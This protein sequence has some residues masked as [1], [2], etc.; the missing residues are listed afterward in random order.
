VDVLVD[1][2][3]ALAPAFGGINLE[4][5]AAPRCFEVERRLQEL[6]D[7]P[8][9]HDDQHGTAVVVLAGLMNAFR[10]RGRELSTARYVINGA[11]AAAIAVTQLLLQA[12]ARDVTVCDRSGAIHR[13]RKGGMNPFKRDLAER[14]NPDGRRGGLADVLVGADVFVGLSAAG[15]V[16]PEMVRSMAPEPVVFALANPV[17]EIL[18]DEARAAGAAIVATGRSDFPNQV[19]NSL[20]FP[21][22]FRGALDVRARRIDEGMK[23]AAADAIAGSV[24]PAELGP[25]KIVPAAMDFSVPPRVAEAVARAAQESGVARVTVDPAEVSRRLTEYIYEERLMRE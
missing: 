21:G 23:L 24:G 4:D 1:A 15:A 7:I 8:V 13:G 14:T 17:P 16:T 22:I 25:E 20:A 19:N 2:V 18:P 9:F 5:I 12:G 6:L 10:V 11:G 3:R